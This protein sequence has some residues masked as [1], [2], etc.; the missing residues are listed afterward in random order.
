VPLAVYCALLV[1]LL[2]A[3]PLWLDEI[4]DLQSVRD[5]SFSQ[6]LAAIPQNSGG[7]PLGYIT[8]FAAVHLLG[9]SKY[10]GR[11]PS[12]VFSAAAIAGVYY[13]AKPYGRKAAICAACLMALFPLQLRYAVEA[14]PYSQALC[15]S[16]WAT[17][18]FLLFH[19]KPRLPVFAAYT[20]LVIACIYTQPYSIFVPI[21]HATWLLFTPGQ[22]KKAIWVCAA[23][24]IAGLAFLPWYG[25]AS[26]AWRES[27]DGYSFSFGWKS[28]LLVLKELTGAGYAGTIVVVAIACY[29]F[30]ESKSL[31]PSRF[32]H[33][34]GI[35]VPLLLAIIADAIINY[36][37]AIRQFIYVAPF[38]AILCGV[39]VARL[40]D[41]K[42]IWTRGIVAALFLILI[43]GDFHY[44]LKP[45]ENWE[46]A[47]RYLDRE[48]SNDSRCLIFIPE[49]SIRFYSFFAPNLAAHATPDYMRCNRVT[50][51]MS[52]Y[53]VRSR[54]PIAQLVRAGYRLVSQTSFN[55][56]QI[57]EYRA[58]ESV[59][60]R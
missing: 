47:A 16:I 44:F 38:L 29:G 32:L 46:Q 11:L 7:V 26:S 55:G 3:L 17:V 30:R 51:A 48:T 36:F 22:R 39:G 9:F 37:L 27:L 53:D 54:E 42:P 40:L 2:P 12:A 25:F 5:L 6:L 33:L 21:A 24:V 58:T 8:Q 45:H 15:L 41:K 18:V 20:A 10:S 43:A 57:F 59:D 35:I 1:A 31:T 19:E 50:V 49:G 13:L 52:P 60:Y 23:I 56:P 14:R 28:S 4:I 34:A